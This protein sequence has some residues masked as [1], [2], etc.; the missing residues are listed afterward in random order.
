MTFRYADNSDHVK[1]QHTTNAQKHILETSSGSTLRLVRTF[2][3]YVGKLLT[4]GPDA[5]ITFLKT[6]GT[7]KYSAN[8]QFGSFLQLSLATHGT[9]H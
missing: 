6:I 1:L 7:T 8:T 2:E 5:R 9:H 3:R 4:T